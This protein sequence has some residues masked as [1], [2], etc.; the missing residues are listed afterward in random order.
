MINAN[1]KKATKLL[2][3]HF[4]CGFYKDKM[5][6]TEID[7]YIQSHHFKNV[8]DGNNKG[9]RLL[10]SGFWAFYSF[11]VHLLMLMIFDNENYIIIMISVSLH[12]SLACIFTT[13]RKAKL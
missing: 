4:I 6:I 5:V 1:N 10:V 13:E 12:N 7:D 8:M 2:N 3:G 9:F 11:T